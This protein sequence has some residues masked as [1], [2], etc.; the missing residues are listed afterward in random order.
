MREEGGREGTRA[1]PGN[2][3]VSYKSILHSSDVVTC[4]MYVSDPL[5]DSSHA[6][7]SN[8]NILY[9]HCRHSCPFL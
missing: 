3:L 9:L 4:A 7:S 8:F 6:L 5:E 1:K 2:L